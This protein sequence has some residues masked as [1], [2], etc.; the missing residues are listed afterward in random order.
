MEYIDGS[1]SVGVGADAKR[2]GGGGLQR[3]GAEGLLSAMVLLVCP[4]GEKRSEDC[5]RLTEV[6]S[7]IH[8]S[9]RALLSHY[10]WQS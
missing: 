8:K 4:L 9:T 1:V 10:K 2:V 6:R 7:D 3:A 5:E